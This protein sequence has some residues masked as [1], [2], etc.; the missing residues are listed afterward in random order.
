[1]SATAD[2]GLFAGYFETA[3]R[4]PAGQL[5]I[6][7]F[8]HPVTGGWWSVDALFWA[9]LVPGVDSVLISKA[10]LPQIPSSVKTFSSPPDLFLEDALESTGLLI[11]KSSKWAKRSGSGK[12]GKDGSAGSGDAAGGGGGGAAAEQDGGGGAAGSGLGQYSEQTRIS[13]S[14]VDESLVNTDLIEALVAHLISSRGQ[15]QQQQAGGGGKRRGGG[16]D[17]ANAILIFAPG[18]WA[19]LELGF[20]CAA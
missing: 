8:T 2:A 18:G 17:D 12:Q 20:M 15:Q 14:N 6:P 19:G 1:M 4:E 7:G 13:L 9:V 10:C 5:T 16:D 11:G 3:L